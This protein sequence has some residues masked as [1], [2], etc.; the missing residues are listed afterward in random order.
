MKKSSITDLSILNW[1]VFIMNRKM[2]SFIKLPAKNMKPSW[3]FKN[4]LAIKMVDV[5]KKVIPKLNLYEK[6]TNS[7]E[8][9]GKKIWYT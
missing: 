3:S 9:S 1:E 4:L 7:K 5:N 2:P 6:L 8:A